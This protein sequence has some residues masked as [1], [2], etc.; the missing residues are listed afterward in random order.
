MSLSACDSAI[1]KHIES[2]EQV[3]MKPVKINKNH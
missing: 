3:V 1:F 2:I